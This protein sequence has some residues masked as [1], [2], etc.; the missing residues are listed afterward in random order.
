MAV[1]P[2]DSALAR[3][4][5]IVTKIAGPNRTPPAPGASTR[6][7]GGG[8]WL[9]SIDLLDL[10]LACDVA[11]GPVFVSM[12]RSVMASIRTVGDLVAVIEARSPASG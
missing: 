6:L 8:F 11:F 10:M 7:W 4:I 2:A 5:E 12:P 9:D 1:P 3:V